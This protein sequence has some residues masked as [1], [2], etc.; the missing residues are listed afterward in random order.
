[1][2][3][4]SGV[5]GEMRMNWRRAAAAATI[6]AATFRKAARGIVVAA[7]HRFTFISVV[8][9]WSEPDTVE[10]I[11]VDAMKTVAMPGVVQQ[12]AGIGFWKTEPSKTSQN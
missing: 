12:A 11:D 7:D 5:L 8:E 1:M 4:S 10:V 2:V 9:G 3:E 6:L